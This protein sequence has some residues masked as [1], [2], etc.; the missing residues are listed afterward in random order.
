MGKKVTKKKA[1]STLTAEDRAD[2]V[3]FINES[4]DLVSTVL[5]CGSAW[6]NDCHKLADL[7]RE[8]GQKLG[9]KHKTDG[10]HWNSDFE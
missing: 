9:F 2:I 8:L 5:E 4:R 1:K 3:K 6:A 7:G 10:P